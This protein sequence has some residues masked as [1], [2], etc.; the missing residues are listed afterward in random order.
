MKLMYPF[1]DRVNDLN[2]AGMREVRWTLESVNDMDSAQQL[3]NW[4]LVF[5]LFVG[6]LKSKNIYH[7]SV[8]LVI[9]VTADG[10]KN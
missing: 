7:F 1:G 3:R 10:V 4:R 5:I 2:V 6:C 8:K 9:W